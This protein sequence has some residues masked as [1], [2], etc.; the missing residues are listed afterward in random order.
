[1]HVYFIHDMYSHKEIGNVI[2]LTIYV[3]Q[4]LHIYLNIYGKNMKKIIIWMIIEIACTMSI[5]N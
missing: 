5:Y 1:M 2:Y 3:V 4:I